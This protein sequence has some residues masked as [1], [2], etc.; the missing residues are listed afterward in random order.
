MRH[1]ALLLYVIITFPCTPVGEWHVMSRSTMSD[2]RCVSFVLDSRN[3]GVIPAGRNYYKADW[4]KFNSDMSV[5]DNWS[6][7]WS[8]Q[9]IEERL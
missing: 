6:T 3:Q 4:T 8:G 9:K 2:H 5:A 1:K 7:K